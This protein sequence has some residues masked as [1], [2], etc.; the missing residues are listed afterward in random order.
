M[1]IAEHRRLLQ[2]LLEEARDLLVETGARPAPPL[3]SR[4]SATLVATAA[5]PR[6]RR[7]LRAGAVSEEPRAP[8]FEVLA[9]SS[10]W[11]LP[12]GAKPPEGGLPSGPPEG[13]VPRRRSATAFEDPSAKRAREAE[14]V[15]AAEMEEADRRARD[16]ERAAAAHEQAA[17]EAVRQAGAIRARL[18]D[19]ERRAREER[20]SAQQA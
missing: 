12:E 3:L 7:A 8:G 11:S 5:D 4:V 17:R 19:A 1:R 10:E 13:G 18:R 20:E 16:L 9:G 6:A 15:A 2:R 14:R